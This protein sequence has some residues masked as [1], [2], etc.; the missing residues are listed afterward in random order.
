MEYR[1]VISKEDLHTLF[2]KLNPHI[3]PKD[4]CGEEMSDY[5]PGCKYEKYCRKAQEIN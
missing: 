2:A 1:N 5:C 3:Y 4:L